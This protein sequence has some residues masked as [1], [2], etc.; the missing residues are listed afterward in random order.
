MEAPTQLL[1]GKAYQKLQNRA[2]ACS[3]YKAALQKD[4]T[5]VEAFNALVNNHLLSGQEERSLL[6][7]LEFGPDKEWLQRLYA[8]RLQKYSTAEEAEQIFSSLEEDCK[9]EQS[10]DLGAARAEHLFYRSE[11][12]RCYELKQLEF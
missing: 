2:K 9:L 7:S 3:H 6:M 12:A 11:F 10:I 8:S 4:A 1:L 5:C